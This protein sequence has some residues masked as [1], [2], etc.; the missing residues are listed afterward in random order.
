MK[1]LAASHAA[2]E[3]Q[4]E[5]SVRNMGF[6]SYHYFKEKMILVEFLTYL[7]LVSHRGGPVFSTEYLKGI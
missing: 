2:Q 3:G 1:K 6:S 7:L 5:D 4:S